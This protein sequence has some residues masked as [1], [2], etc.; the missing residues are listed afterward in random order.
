[1]DPTT[2]S[3]V[4]GAVLLLIWLMRTNKKSGD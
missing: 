2:I 3:L 1:M 4:I